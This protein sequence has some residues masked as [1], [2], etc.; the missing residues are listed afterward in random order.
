LR[1]RLERAHQLL[2]VLTVYKKR[3]M[4]RLRPLRTFGRRALEADDNRVARIEV[5]LTAY[6]RYRRP[7]NVLRDIGI[8]RA[9][10]YFDG[11]MQRTPEPA[12]ALVCLLQAR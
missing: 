8:E 11:R 1:A 10:I 7:R 3:R 4:M 6:E 12:D 2:H 5:R 9:R